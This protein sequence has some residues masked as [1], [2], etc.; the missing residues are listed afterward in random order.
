MKFRFDNYGIHIE[1]S[2]PTFM[3]NH[4][5]NTLKFNEIQDFIY[6]LSDALGTDISNYTISRL[7]TTDN[8]ETD[9]SPR[10]YKKYLG[11]C[12]YF[13]KIDYEFNGIH[14]I[15]GTRHL[16]LYDKVLEQLNKNMIIP[17][18]FYSKNLLR[19]E[20][21]VKKNCRYHLGENIKEVKD[22]LIPE[23][24]IFLIDK[25]EKMFN[26]IQKFE[27]LNSVDSGFPYKQIL[28]P[29]E[30]I[31]VAWA[32]SIGGVFKAISL[33]NEWE[34]LGYCSNRTSRTLRSNL[35]K[36]QNKYNLV[37]SVNTDRKAELISKFQLKVE[38]NRLMV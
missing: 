31:N 33:I 29:R 21:S 26:S 9:Y 36:Y 30:Y 15:N 6:R 13:Q 22:L 17:P 12:D 4:N 23:N 18:E 7:D 38:E 16:T 28:K 35:M 20:Y 19:F 14:Y 34:D 25:W 10:V 24:F 1:G 8:I 32:D 2:A 3:N 37:D 5:I 27:E 11:R